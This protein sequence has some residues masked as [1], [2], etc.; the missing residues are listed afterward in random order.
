VKANEFREKTG[1]ELRQLLKERQADL[2]KFRID[3]TT[4]VVDNN[5]AIR[6]ARRDIARVKTIFREREIAAAQAGGKQ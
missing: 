4:G 6:E 5:R 1:D 3:I 2:V